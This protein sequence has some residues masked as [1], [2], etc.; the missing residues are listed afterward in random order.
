FGQP[1]YSHDDVHHVH[2]SPAVMLIPL[3]I[4][5][6]L[7]IFAGWVGVPAALGG[8]DL[9][10]TYING[11]VE[12]AHRGV[13]VAHGTELALMAAATAIGLIGFVL[14][15]VF[16]V[17]KPELPTRI[18]AGAHALYGLL[19]NKYYV[20]EIYDS[21]VVWPVVRTSREFLWK[22]VDVVI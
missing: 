16:Y 20:D 1:R 5:A 11:G 18:S 7:S 3:V 15:Y 2:E 22:F 14:A 10:T 13:E 6:V 4:L 17:A 9:I 19:L 8:N 12:I 21:L